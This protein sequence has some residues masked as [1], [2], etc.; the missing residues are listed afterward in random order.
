MAEATAMKATSRRISVSETE[1]P[2]LFCAD[3]SA[4][5]ARST[6]LPVWYQEI[7]DS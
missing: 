3:P 1:K 2:K 6:Y 4:A 7:E 5:N